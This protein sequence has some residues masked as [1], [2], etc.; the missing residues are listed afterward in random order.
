MILVTP[1]LTYPRHFGPIA[2]KSSLFVRNEVVSTRFGKDVNTKALLHNIQTLV[3]PPGKLKAA[4]WRSQ[5]RQAEAECAQAAEALSQFL[6]E[7]FTA[8][9]LAGEKPSRVQWNF[10]I[11]N[12][13]QVRL[14]A[15]YLPDITAIRINL[16]PDIRENMC[17]VLQVQPYKERLVPIKMNILGDTA[18][19]FAALLRSLKNPFFVSHVKSFPDY[20]STQ[21]LLNRL[22]VMSRL[23]AP[24]GLSHDYAR[25]EERMAQVIEK[26]PQPL[27]QFLVKQGYRFEI[28]RDLKQDRFMLGFLFRNHDPPMLRRDEKSY[29]PID[30]NAK[31]IGVPLDVQHHNEVNPLGYAVHRGLAAALLEIA[32]VQ[33]NAFKSQLLANYESD[34]KQLRVNDWQSASDIQGFLTGEWSMARLAK[35]TPERLFNEVFA[36]LMQRRN[37]PSYLPLGISTKHPALLK[38]ENTCKLV[39]QRIIEPLEKHGWP[40]FETIREDYD[41]RKDKFTRYRPGATNYN[42]ILNSRTFPDAG[43]ER[44]NEMCP[45]IPSAMYGFPDTAKPLDR[46][47]PNEN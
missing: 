21:A 37:A 12:P 28:F 2:P 31:H 32:G 7:A 14:E 35:P 40:R 29:P 20:Q 41:I 6:P 16:V 13:R 10:S 27:R 33:A 15:S 4:V 44:L 36:A 22:D 26:Y 30:K 43:R 46:R 47:P 38:L 19:I 25:A 23:V 34:L 8:K 17:L 45:V 24:L 18:Q 39:E 1:A 5:S 42:G 3:A 11:D 9:I